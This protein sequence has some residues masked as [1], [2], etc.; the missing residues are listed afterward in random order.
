MKKIHQR[1]FLLTTA[2][3]NEMAEKK[4]QEAFKRLA[5]SAEP[6]AGNAMMPVTNPIHRDMERPWP[7]VDEWDLYT[8]G[9]FTRNDIRSGIEMTADTITIRA[10]KP[11]AVLYAD[12]VPMEWD[13]GKEKWKCPYCGGIRTGDRCQGC[14]APR[15]AGER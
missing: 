5:D 15:T 12:N 4:M 11:D 3:R 7:V 2:G 13:D 8:E 14:G 10:A 1:R 6:P 9:C